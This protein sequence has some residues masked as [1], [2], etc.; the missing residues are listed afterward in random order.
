[1]PLWTTSFDDFGQMR[2]SAVVSSLF[3]ADA[4][5]S[6]RRRPLPSVPTSSREIIDFAEHQCVAFR[7]TSFGGSQ[8]KVRGS[9]PAIYRANTDPGVH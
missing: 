5:P 2:L 7:L 6:L 9:E 1:M 3:V 8:W 4:P